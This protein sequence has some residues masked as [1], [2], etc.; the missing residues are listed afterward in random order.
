MIIGLLALAYI[1]FGS[2]HQTFLLNPNLKKNVDTYVSDKNRKT[3]IYQVIKQVEKREENFLKQTKKVYDKKL[4]NLNMNRTS[5]TADF[6]MEYDKFY[7]SLK[8]LQNG[9]LDS[10]LK[11][12]SLIH[13][14]EWDSIM[15]K[16]LQQPD[17]GK[18][19]KNLFEENQKL[20]DKLLKACEKYIPDSTRKAKANT[21]ADE[22]KNKGDTLADAFLNLN[23]RYIETIRPYDVT[24]KDF[25]PMRAEMLALR[26]N[27]SDYLVEMRFELLSITPEKQ[28]NDFAKELNTNFVYMGAGIS[29]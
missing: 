3:E 26:R 22:Y 20:H 25:E 27:Y 10:E 16:V 21:F 28:W 2:G 8:D 11:I 9:Y 15:N 19:R 23:Y 6:K 17:K 24:R 5:T 1:F 14:N 7:D 12:R 4:V 29:K 18:A 13:P